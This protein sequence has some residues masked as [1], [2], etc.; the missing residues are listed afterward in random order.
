MTT[1]KQLMR[2][3][4]GQEVWTNAFGNRFGERVCVG[5]E[6][7]K[8]MREGKTFTPT[9]KEVKDLWDDYIEQEVG[10][11]SQ[12]ARELREEFGIMESVQ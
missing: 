6:D 10:T 5:I 4:N 11:P 9:T 8:C 3:M 2:E 7:G 12:I 1:R